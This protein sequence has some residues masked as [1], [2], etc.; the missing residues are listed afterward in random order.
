MLYGAVVVDVFNLIYRV[1][2]S[3]K[4]TLEVANNFINYIELSIKPYLNKKGIIYFLFDPITKTDLGINKYFNVSTN[5]QDIVATYK[6]NRKHDSLVLSAAKFIKQYYTYKGESFVSYVSDYLEADDYVEPLLKTFVSKTTVA[7]ITTYLDWAKYL[8]NTVYI[9]NKNFD[10]PFGVNEYV[11]K[12]KFIPTPASVTLYKS[13]FGDKS[14]NIQGA[15]TSKQSQAL[16]NEIEQYINIIV[17]ENE[18]LDVIIKRLKSYNFALI[19]SKKDRTFEEELWLKL[20]STD[21]K[22]NIM[23][24]FFNN[25][26]IIK[27]RCNN[28]E[29]HKI[30]EPIN[31]KINKL[32]E[33]TLGRTAKS[34]GKY[35]FGNSSKKKTVNIK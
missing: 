29:T 23:S 25:V 13:F 30:S 8:S 3:E 11:K 12:Y 5:R 15:I 31:E 16:I 21:V 34:K 28:L 32:L 6:S 10:N 18:S 33:E 19:A 26:R 9:I 22:I 20:N 27:S 17:K 1:K 2:K 14:D 4:E 24:T 7:L 35:K